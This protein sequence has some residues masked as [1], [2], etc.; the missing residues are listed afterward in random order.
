MEESD[1]LGGQVVARLV[2]EY[3]AVTL[4]LTEGSSRPR[5]VISGDR[6]GDRIVLDA[7]VLEAIASLDPESVDR[8]VQ[9]FSETGLAGDAVATDTGV[10]LN[11]ATGEPL[12][13]GGEHE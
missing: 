4:L 6:T 12:D 3:A 7:V 1:N 10:D 2:N 8:L 13:P 11:R 9:V 5:L